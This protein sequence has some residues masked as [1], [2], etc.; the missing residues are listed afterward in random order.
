MTVQIGKPQFRNSAPRNIFKIKDGSNLF[1]ILPP[2]GALAE[3]GT[4]AVYAK[5]HWGVKTSDGKY[6][7]FYC[8]EKKD[9]KTKM[10]TERCALCDA[11]AEKKVERDA[12]V[13]KF[14]DQGLGREEIVV[15]TKFLEDWLRKYNL[16]TKW[17]VN[18]MNREGEVGLLKFAHSYYK[19]LEI[20][21]GNLMYPE[22]GPDGK[23]RKPVD[24][25]GAEDGVLFDFLYKEGNQKTRVQK[26]N[27]VKEQ[28]DV[29]GEIVEVTKRFPLTEAMITKFIDGHYDLSNL[30][31]ILTPKEIESIVSS[32]FS[33][34]VIDSIYTAGR[35][36]AKAPEVAKVVEAEE[37]EP[38][39]TVATLPVAKIQVEEA[40]APQAA[41]IS[42]AASSDDDFFAQFQK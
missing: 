9:N 21:I 26:V 2:I 12:Q 36:V 10:V 32:K 19:D 20:H 13:K 37:E 6:M 16:E 29:G 27:I 7:N 14:T 4:W 22:K 34:D 24:P 5:I 15:K 33:T 42:A 41:P 11:I 17:N 3:K 40:P 25:I 18:V 39:E 28:R 35:A 23:P 30:A 38:T 1:R 31:R 8:V